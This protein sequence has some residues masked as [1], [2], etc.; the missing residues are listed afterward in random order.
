M[1]LSIDIPDE[2]HRQVKIKAINEGTTVTAVVKKRLE[3]YV[4]AKMTAGF[5]ATAHHDEGGVKV[6]DSAKL[7]AVSIDSKPLQP[8]TFVRPISK[9]DQAKGRSRK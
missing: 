7:M 8:G 1:R 3:E 2:L 4:S 6:I 5:L 9:E